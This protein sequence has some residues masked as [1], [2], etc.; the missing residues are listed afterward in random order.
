[1]YVCHGCDVHNGALLRKVIAAFRSFTRKPPIN[2]IITL[3]PAPPPPSPCI[4]SGTPSCSHLFLTPPSLQLSLPAPL[5]LWN[6]DS[7]ECADDIALTHHF[8]EH[9]NTWWR[10]EEGF[11]FLRRASPT[12]SIFSM[13]RAS[14]EHVWMGK[15]CAWPWWLCVVCR[16]PLFV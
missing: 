12:R 13:L 4:W 14:N 16:S 3:H 15:D 5:E 10:S 9:R 8:E 7:F 11:F 6:N 2:G 1:M